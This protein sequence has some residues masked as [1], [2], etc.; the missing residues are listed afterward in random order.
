MRRFILIG[1]VVGM[2][3]LGLSAGLPAQA[4][5]TD[6][7]SQV[8]F[9]ATNLDKFSPADAA[10][11]K[12]LEPSRIKNPTERAQY[13]RQLTALQT[14]QTSALRNGATDAQIATISS[15]FGVQSI[16]PGCQ[17]TSSNPGGYDLCAYNS[18]GRLVSSWQSGRYQR[19]WGGV[20]ETD[21][22]SR[23]RVWIKSQATG[24][25]DSNVNHQV[26]IN[27]SAWDGS[28]KDAA[29]HWGRTA[30][31]GFTAPCAP[32]YWTGAFH[33]QLFDMLNEVTG[34]VSFQREVVIIN[35]TSDG[36]DT[37]HSAASYW[38]MRA[39]GNSQCNGPRGDGIGC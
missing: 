37:L 7:S 4:T 27:Y 9:T 5:P 23:W 34:G 21:T 15:P 39:N 33:D 3:L 12:M 24:V 14:A 30:D 26:D 31:P 38:W 13:Q 35:Q 8:D 16:D 1:T 36:S 11:L 32:C 22:N 25:T 29:W 6:W 18:N 2:L 10:L 17:L 20:Q 19:M 28:S